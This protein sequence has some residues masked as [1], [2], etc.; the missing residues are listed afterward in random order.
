[1]AG[2]KLHPSVEQFKAF[3]KEHPILIKLVRDDE[4]TWQE[5]YEDWYLL[6]EDDPK[7]T[8]YKNGSQTKT[9]HKKDDDKNWVQQLTGVFKKMDANQMQHHINN[10]SQA[11]GAIQ[12]VLTQFQGNNQEN[13]NTQ[14]QN[15][16]PR[17]PFSFRKD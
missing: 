5:L 1:M 2:K 3:V 6:G 16:A 15:D 8:Q 4:Y 13:T 10:L 9:S 17:N 7:W 12:G 14:P 11:I